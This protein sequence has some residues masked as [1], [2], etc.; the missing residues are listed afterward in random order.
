MG[1]FDN[2]DSMLTAALGYATAGLSVFPCI[3]RTKEPA[4]KRGFHDATTNP[5][6]IRRWWNANPSYN[7]G[8]RTG[9]ASGFFVLDIDGAEGERNLD[10][11]QQQHGFLPATAEATTARGR[12]LWFRCAAPIPCSAGRIA[13]GVDVRAD[14]GYVVA[15]PSVHPSGRRY[16]WR[17]EC[18]LAE[19][20]SWLLDLARKKP[21]ITQQALAKVRLARMAVSPGN[22][23]AAALQAEIAALAGAPQGQRNHALNRAAFSLA[24]LVGGGELDQQIVIDGLLHACERNGLLS[25]PDDGLRKCER[26]IESGMTAGMQQPRNREG[27]A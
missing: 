16:A 19:A 12:H 23:G 27:R 10:Q 5:A 22:Y 13:S 15:P 7:I 24:Q 3:P 11:L 21:T 18:S 17:S 8:V 20:P 2:T 14:G 1:D 6:T 9:M 4:T 25:D 26:T